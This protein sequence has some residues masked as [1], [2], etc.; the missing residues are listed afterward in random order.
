MGCGGVWLWG[1]GLEFLFFHGFALPSS[2]H[3]SILR[4]ASKRGR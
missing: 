4:Q 2:G 3:G 1:S